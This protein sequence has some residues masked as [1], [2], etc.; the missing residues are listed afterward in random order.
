[1]GIR[2]KLT[3]EELAYAAGIID[4]EG[5]IMICKW[6]MELSKKYKCV[7]PTFYLRC[8][9]T[10]TEEK[11]V[12]FFYNRWGASKKKRDRTHR[13]PKWKICYEWTIQSRMA[14]E[15]LKEIYP[16]LITKKEKARIAIDFQE[17]MGKF[18]K[19]QLPKEE[20]A[21]RNKCW[22]QL[23]KQNH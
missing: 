16:Y 19:K 5:H 1:M 7:S 20:V 21:R 22:G 9:M 17:G 2:G 23:N 13:N 18:G 11:M 3:N 6:R 4:G 14:M 8:G 15:F 10:N 12:D